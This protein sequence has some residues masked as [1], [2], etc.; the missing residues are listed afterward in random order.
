MEREE[1]V[2]PASAGPLAQLWPCQLCGLRA[3]CRFCCGLDVNLP[4]SLCWMQVS[5]LFFSAY[6]ENRIR[7]SSPSVQQTSLSVVILS[8]CFAARNAA[9]AHRLETGGHG[10]LLARGG[11]TGDER[12]KLEAMAAV[13]RREGRGD[14]RVPELKVRPSTTLTLTTY[15]QRAKQ[16]LLSFLPSLLSFVLS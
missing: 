12:R 13:H 7:D 16:C 15:H 14:L 4:S 5:F 8:R 9:Q 2:P 11:A 10:D 1:S 6:G 3:S